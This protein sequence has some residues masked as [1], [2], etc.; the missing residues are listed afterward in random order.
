[1]RNSIPAEVYVEEIIKLKENK[2]E[3]YQTDYFKLVI[4]LLFFF[5]TIMKRRIN[6]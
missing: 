5:E 6:M 4:F 3:K 2:A 1:M